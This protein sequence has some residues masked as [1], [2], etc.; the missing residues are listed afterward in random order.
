MHKHQFYTVSFLYLTGTLYHTT[1]AMKSHH[2][3]AR[4]T[5]T[6]N[7]QHNSNTQTHSIKNSAGSGKGTYAQPSL[8]AWLSA[9]KKQLLCS[10]AL[11]SYSLTQLA[12]WYLQAKAKAATRGTCLHEEML[13]LPPSQNQIVGAITQAGITTSKQTLDGLFHTIDN[14]K[15]AL[16]RFA[17]CVDWLKKF[18]IARF[19]FYN[20]ELHQSSSTRL[21]Y[22]ANLEQCFLEHLQEFLRE[23]REKKVAYV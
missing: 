19:F 1:L 6:I 15:Q 22:L 13:V 4:Y 14:E 7:I 12:L 10:T 9:R 17:T 18:G 16:H 2:Y 11:L 21:Q 8:L 3:P 5:A 20:R 23:I